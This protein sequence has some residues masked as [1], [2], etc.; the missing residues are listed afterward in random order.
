MLGN[1]DRATIQ[2]EFK[3]PVDS[4]HPGTYW[5]ACL[6]YESFLPTNLELLQIRSFIEFSTKRTYREHYQTKIL[7]K[8]LASCSGHN[9]LIFLKGLRSNESDQGWRFRRASWEIGPMYVPSITDADYRP[10]TLVEVMDIVEKNIP[11][12]WQKWKQEHPEIFPPEPKEA[13][14]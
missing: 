8:P 9:T 1:T 4:S 12:P 3:V 13:A 10:H 6:D 5:I 14:K 11:E 2:D 7:E